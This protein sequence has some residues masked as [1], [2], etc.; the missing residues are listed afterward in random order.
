MKGT[1]G[2]RIRIIVLEMGRPL[3]IIDDDCD[4]DLPSPA[5]EHLLQ[6]GRAAASDKRT[7]PLLA[8]I[9]ITRAIPQLTRTLKAPVISSDTLEIF[10]RHFRMCLATF[11]PEYR[12]KTDLYLTP[13]SLA[14]IIYLQNTRLMLHR[15]NLS[16]TCSP[17]MRHLALDQCLAV[18]QDTTRILLRCMRPP[19]DGETSSGNSVANDWRYNLAAAASTVLSTHIWRCLLFLLFRA[20][21]GAALVCI[22]ACS[23]IG[24]SRAVNICA[25]RYISFFL[26][27]LLE[28]RQ[29]AD[30]GSLERDEEMMAYVSGDFQ[31]R[32]EGSWVW[33][34]SDVQSPVGRHSPG[35]TSSPQDAVPPAGSGAAQPPEPDPEWEGWESIERTVKFLLGE[36][37]RTVALPERP[38]PSSVSAHDSTRADPIPKR[39]LSNHSQT[40]GNSSRMTIANII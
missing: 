7:S 5:D 9:H 26:R 33:R 23:A 39:P 36:Q 32:I 35:S 2:A 40:S 38:E 4:V 20:D 27:C 17:E 16:P 29:R 13:R 1:N 10:E 6:D 15:R 19:T 34:N 3:F 30:I 37:K 12:M 11:P 8:V 18:S 28:K 21:Y 22:Q 14:P 25:G 24:D 31:S